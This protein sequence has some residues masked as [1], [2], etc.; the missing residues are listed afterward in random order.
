[1]DDIMKSMANPFLMWLFALLGDAF[2]IVGIATAVSEV[3]IACFTPTAWLL[4]AVISYLIMVWVVTLRILI[5]V[6][7]REVS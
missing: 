4:L 6:E 5:R 3:S 7:S 2:L 1:M